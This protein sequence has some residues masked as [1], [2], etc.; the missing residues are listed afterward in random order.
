[1]RLT[2]KVSVCFTLIIIY[3]KESIKVISFVICLFWVSLT[4]SENTSIN[5]LW[6]SFTHTL[7]H[8]CSAELF[9]PSG[10]ISPSKR[11]T[12]LSKSLSEHV[13]SHPS[14]PPESIGFVLLLNPLRMCFD[15]LWNHCLLRI[16]SPLQSTEPHQPKTSTAVIREVEWPSRCKGLDRGPEIAAAPAWWQMDDVSDYTKNPKRAICALFYFTIYKGVCKWVNS[17]KKNLCWIWFAWCSSPVCIV[18]NLRLWRRHI[19]LGQTSE[20]AF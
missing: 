13:Y 12:T 20:S 7:A 15:Q 5:P 10:L 6:L 9:P 11:L 3:G 1:M 8:S 14:L 2:Q 19:L 17:K 4:R 16:Y 18:L